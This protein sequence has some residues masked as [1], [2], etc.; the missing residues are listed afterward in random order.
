MD[1]FPVYEHEIT[2]EVCRQTYKFRYLFND[3]VKSK[4][5]LEES[6]DLSEWKIEIKEIL[7]ELKSL[8]KSAAENEILRIAKDRIVLTKHGNVNQLQ[9]HDQV[10]DLFKDQQWYESNLD[11]NRNLLHL[12]QIGIFRSGEDMWAINIEK[13]WLNEK[14]I[15]Y[16]LSNKGGR[17]KGWILKCILSRAS[18]TVTERL[19][20]ISK[21]YL[22]EYILARKRKNTELNE[23]HTIKKITFNGRHDAYLV[24]IQSKQIEDTLQEYIDM[25]CKIIVNKKLS[26]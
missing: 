19:Q 11:Y 24:Q 16:D 3:S 26:C 22:K 13:Q 2:K 21:H 17:R 7:N 18:D 6:N 8:G 25:I 15:C 10:F 5:F 9:T 20:N 4:L 14:S 12:F 1:L 23:N